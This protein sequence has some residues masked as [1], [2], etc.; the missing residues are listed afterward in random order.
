M[1]PSRRT[2]RPTGRQRRALER[3]A[4]PEGRDAAPDRL[5][6]A[7]ALTKRGGSRRSVLLGFALGLLILLSYFP[8]LS[9]G[10]VWDDTIFV[11]E[12]VMREGVSGL[13]KIWSSPSAI[14]HEGHYWPIVYTS[15]WLERQLWGL[16]PF[17]Y[18]LL[19]LLLHLLCTLLIWR[20]LLRLEVP[21]AFFAAAAFAVHPLHVESV[22][23]V[24]E[25]KD[26]LSGAFFLGAFLLW[27]RF[28]R[29]PGPGSYLGSLLAFVAALLSKSIAVTLPASFLLERFWKAGRVERRDVL[30]TAPFF[31]VGLAITVADVAYYRT[32]EVVE[33]DYS[34]LERVL[35][36][37]R[38]LWFYA[39]KVIWP[40]ELPVIYPLWDVRSSDPVAWAYLLAAIAI[41]A[42]AW[43]GRRHVGRA[44]L[45]ALLFFGVTLSPVLGFVNYGY[46]QYAFVA[47]RFQYLAG[48]GIIALVI[49]GAARGANALPRGG[50]VAVA[51]SFVLVLAVFS[52]GT[53]RQSGIYRAPTA[54]FGHI[55]S[56]NPDARDAY[57]N[58]TDALI[59]EGRHEEALDAA[60]HAMK[61]SANPANAH[62]NLGAA[63][64]NLERFE[65]GEKHLHR[66]L[67]LDPDHRNATHNLGEL[68]RRQGQHETAAGFYRQAL[69]MDGDYGL[70]A[71]GLGDAL[72]QLG[73][74][75][76]AA[77]ALG[78]ALVMRPDSDVAANLRSMRAQSLSELGRLEEA[79]EEYRVLVRLQPA[80]RDPLLRLAGVLRRQGRTE[81]ADV[82]IRRAR[83]TG[84]ESVAFLQN[85]AEALRDQGLYEKAL[86]EYRRVLELD[87]AFGS[88]HAGRAA[89]LFELGRYEAAIEALERS[90]AL[91]PEVSVRPAREVLIGR[92]FVELG[93][94]EEEAAERY[95]RALELDPGHPDALDRL[96][97]L[98]F[99]QGRYRE[100]LDLYRA[101]LETDPDS[102]QIHSNIGAA[103]YYLNRREEA[104]QS[105][106]RALA[107]D[108]GNETAQQ[109]LERLRQDRLREPQR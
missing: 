33:L 88:A 81:E 95:L 80:S 48:L 15:F 11:E 38:A 61:T 109:N 108:P 105:F 46:M 40:G 6:P 82:H 52:V 53:F 31:A 84:P 20:L 34:L 13:A 56:L 50:R 83:E 37:A 49:A 71:A 69:E 18:H 106:E 72:F 79:A 42:A 86:D 2:T 45:T 25:R 41:G 43:F 14:R 77:E 101:H 5:E 107:L 76:E 65:E 100:A 27:L 19:N 12:P 67:E 78:R 35:I 99:G 73:R 74:H 55:V 30:R 68:F 96:G 24:I 93:R 58:L 29:N 85:V 26:L 17:P 21:G 23:W 66:V 59:E 91:E 92:A 90:I 47:D 63:L 9:A 70:A 54:F 62:A 36:A 94:P 60:E 51:G 1:T 98:R 103:L 3:T 64:L 10:F 4:A 8:T 87:P 89:T 75:E 102:P 7:S 97:L 22:A 44:P 16:E 57:L 104:L 32:R 39:G 28:V